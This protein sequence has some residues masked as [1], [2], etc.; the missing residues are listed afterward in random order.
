[1]RRAE[2][3]IS[4]QS[5]VVQN[6]IRRHTIPLAAVEAFRPG[7]ATPHG[8]NP[9]PGIVVCLAGGQTLPVWALAE[10]STIFGAKQRT[11]AFAP[12]ADEL[13]ALLASV[14]DS[15]RGR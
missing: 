2:L 10:E 7:D 4:S 6:P 9:T 5:I 11:R 12:L 13:N 8:R 3:R 15:G 14:R 1:M